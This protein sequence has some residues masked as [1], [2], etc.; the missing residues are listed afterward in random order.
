MESSY[1]DELQEIAKKYGQTLIDNDGNWKSIF[2]VMDIFAKIWND[3]S[4]KDVATMKQMG[5]KVL[6]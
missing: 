2:E 5:D 3:V 4:A 6:I 1:I